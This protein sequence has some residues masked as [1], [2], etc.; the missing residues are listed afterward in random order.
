VH[1]IPVYRHPYYEARGYKKGLCP[2]AELFS[3][4]EISIPIFPA[5]SQK[6]QTKIIKV[7]REINKQ[8]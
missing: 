8:L 3:E 2:N 6:D 7:I 5:L 1:Y 4:S